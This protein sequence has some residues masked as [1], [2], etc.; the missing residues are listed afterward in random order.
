V[1]VLA[2]L[3]NEKLAHLCVCFFRIFK[4]KLIMRV[5]IFLMFMMSLTLLHGQE[6]A[7]SNWII[8]PSIGYQHQEKSFLKA[9]LWALKDIGYANYLRFDAGVNMTFQDKKAY[10]I[11]ELGATYY[12]SAKG[13]WPF[14]KA[15]LTPYTVTPKVGLG[16]FNILEAAIGY[17]F[18]IKQKDPLPP[19][20]GFNFSMGLSIPL[21]Y[22]LR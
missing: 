19:I 5:T 7:K 22:H 6:V 14:I 20:K 4:Y 10:F 3:N 11:P 12:L 2:N 21:N 8:G 9:S 13:V 15:E 17:G 16:V 1:S 18:D